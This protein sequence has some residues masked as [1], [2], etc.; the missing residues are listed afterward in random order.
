MKTKK[1]KPK[2]VTR[3]YARTYMLRARDA[4]VE[5]L[6]NDDGEWI[7]EG[8]HKTDKQLDKCPY[9]TEY[10]LRMDELNEEFDINGNRIKTKVS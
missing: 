10:F 5:D 9:C 1:R 2:F 7:C 4:Y 3:K 6:L 8:D